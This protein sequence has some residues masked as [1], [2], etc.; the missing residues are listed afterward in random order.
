MIVL[1]G[2]FA[3]CHYIEDTIYDTGVAI[4]RIYAGVSVESVETE[5]HG[6]VAYLHRQGEGPT[7]VL[8]H[9]FAA[10]KELWL[11]LIRE[12]PSEYD[13]VALDLP[14]H[15]ASERLP[16]ARYRT[17][18]FTEGVEDALGQI[19]PGEF[20]LLGSSVGGM[21]AMRYTLR[22]PDQVKTLALISPA[23]FHPPVQSEVERRLAEGENPLLIESREEF[24]RFTD[25]L[26]YERTTMPWP[27]GSVLSRRSIE[28]SEHR[29]RMWNDLWESRE[30]MDEELADFTLP[31]LLVWGAEDKVVD[32]S[33]VEVFRE[34]VVN[35]PLEV[36]VLEETG[37][38]PMLERPEDLG[39]AYRRF[40]AEFTSAAPD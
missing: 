40:L 28:R 5:S 17:E 23:A 26:F 27:I 24:E 21:I 35:A 14:G 29:Q 32:V 4:T 18:D 8:L 20:H 33:G 37:H 30:E 22:H 2:V 1:G 19:V 36:L 16:D 7:I 9:G 34:T 15:G 3:G 6:R 31:I 13:V 38:S 39:A 11:P 10:Q 12:I 25:L